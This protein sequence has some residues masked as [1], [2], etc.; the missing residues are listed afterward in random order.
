MSR[1]GHVWSYLYGRRVLDV[2]GLWKSGLQAQGFP[3]ISTYF[4]GFHIQRSSNGHNMPQWSYHSVGIGFPPPTDPHRLPLRSLSHEASRCI[5]PS[6]QPVLEATEQQVLN[7]LLSKNRRLEDGVPQP[8]WFI[9]S[10]ILPTTTTGGILGI[11]PFWDKTIDI[12]LNPWNASCDPGWKLPLSVVMT[13]TVELPDF[14]NAITPPCPASQVP[15]L[16]TETKHKPIQIHHWNL[17]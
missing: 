13:V 7:C 17:V 14:I 1:L 6:P 9:I 10:T 15:Q 3:W 16:P 11:T 12:I 8:S 5:G 2:E 4:N